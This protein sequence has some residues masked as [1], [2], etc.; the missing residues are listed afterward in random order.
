[1]TPLSSL[2]TPGV[3]VTHPSHPEWGVGQVQS[4]VGGRI[5]VNFPEEGKVVIDSNRVELTPVF[6]S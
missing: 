5:T 4:N 1:M 6:D 2:F 3:L